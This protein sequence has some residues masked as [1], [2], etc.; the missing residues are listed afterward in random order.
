MYHNK[1]G[2]WCFCPYSMVQWW[3][4]PC[5]FETKLLSTPVLQH[6]LKMVGLNGNKKR[7][8][9]RHQHEKTAIPLS[10][11]LLS[12]CSLEPFPTRSRD[13][14]FFVARQR[15][16]LPPSNSPPAWLLLPPS[17]SLQRVSSLRY[18]PLDGAARILGYGEYRRRRDYRRGHGYRG[19]VFGY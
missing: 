14:Q 15:L 17:R 7:K 9:K 1:L 4:Y 11:F 16:L 8:K 18:T 5:Y 3:F 2:I 13:L 10:P 6:R 12:H 19:R